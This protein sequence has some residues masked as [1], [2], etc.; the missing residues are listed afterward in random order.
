MKKAIR[1]DRLKALIKKKFGTRSR[2]ADLAGEDRYEVQK[3]FMTAYA[4]D[5]KYIEYRKTLAVKALRL[6]RTGRN[7]ELSI[8][9][10]DALKRA[11]DADGGTYAVA[12]ALNVPPSS[13]YELYNGQR[14][15]ITPFV[16]NVLD[17]YSIK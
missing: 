17:K 6:K 7:G 2:F 15:V 10:L 12:K 8:T 13:L 9:L 4:R 16:Q 5:P 11:I 1:L 3:A 14:M